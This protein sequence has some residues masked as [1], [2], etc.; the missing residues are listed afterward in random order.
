[1]ASTGNE[2]PLPAIPPKPDESLAQG[3]P[4]GRGVIHV[5]STP[6]G[7]EVWLLVGITPQM[8]LT[9]IEA[10]R[11]YTLRVDKDGYVEGPLHILAEEWRDGGDPK[12]PLS[13]APKKAELDRD[14]TLSPVPKGP[15]R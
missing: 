4:A 14:V 5:E 6:K 2:P 10:G 15:R 13:A 8:D 11:D 3:A 12:L 7:A 1:V 9:G